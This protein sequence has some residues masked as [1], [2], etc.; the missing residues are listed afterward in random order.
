M[1]TKMLLTILSLAV[2]CSAASK[3]SVM[4]DPEAAAMRAAGMPDLCAM[5]PQFCE[6]C[7]GPGLPACPPAEDSGVLCCSRDGS[8][9]VPS[10][11]S[12]TGGIQGYC[13]HFTSSTDPATGLTTAV[14][15]DDQGG[16]G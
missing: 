16:G 11:G 12:C 5:G 15:H 7:G 6:P 1:T 13:Q 14:C 2:S 9:C 3:S 4:A 8:V 10:T